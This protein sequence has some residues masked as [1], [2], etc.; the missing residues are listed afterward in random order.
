MLL[1]ALCLARGK[2]SVLDY[3]NCVSDTLH[4]RRRRRKKKFCMKNL[5]HNEIR[6]NRILGRLKRYKRKKREYCCCYC[7]IFF[8]LSWW[9][10]RERTNQNI[11]Y[12]LLC[13]HCW[14]TVKDKKNRKEN[15]IE[16][17]FIYFKET[18]LC[19]WSNKEKS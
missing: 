14:F 9:P 12:N 10:K 3:K 4:R 6:E 8:L 13:I 2:I 17:S 15:I 5:Q 19:C 16:F 7:Q 11:F 18:Y 1:H